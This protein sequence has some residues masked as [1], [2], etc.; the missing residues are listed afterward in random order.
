MTAKN[1]AFE[2]A[3]LIIVVELLVLLYDQRVNA[4]MHV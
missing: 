2:K 1:V 4:V 3:S